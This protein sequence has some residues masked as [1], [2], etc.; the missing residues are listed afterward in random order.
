MPCLRGMK[1][2]NNHVLINYERDLNY[3]ERC[4]LLVS[5][6]I[7]SILPVGLIKE[8]R[9]KKGIF[10]ITGYRRLKDIEKLSVEKTLSL[11]ELITIAYDNIREY[12]VFI[13]E[14]VITMD[15]TFVNDSFTEVKFIYAISHHYESEKDSFLYL[16]Y[17]LKDKT[18]ELNFDIVGTIIEHIKNN[19]FST[20]KIR[21]LI[22]EIKYEMK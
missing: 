10:D 21:E 16:I 13:E 14:M 20:I 4:E 8:N 18:K 22:S 12:P 17:S 2:M 19:G 6:V 1:L 7:K 15:T 3:P 5:G 9:N 11:I